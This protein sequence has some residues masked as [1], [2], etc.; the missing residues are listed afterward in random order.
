VNNGHI[1]SKNR[2]TLIDPRTGE[3]VKKSDT[4]WIPVPLVFALIRERGNVIDYEIPIT[5]DLNDPKFNFWDPIK[6]VLGNIFIKP[7]TVAYG[8]H[9][10]NVEN[11]LEK[12]INIK[13]PFHSYLITGETEKFVGK[14][15]KFLEENKDA[16]LEI[17]PN[18]HEEKEKEFI[19]I[20]EAKK[21]FFLHK[22]KKNRKN[23]KEE[24]SM[25]VEKMANKDP[26]FLAYL[27]KRISDPLLFTVQHKSLNVVGE[28][29]VVAKYE[30]L[31]TNRK[32][33]FLSCFPEE[34]R[35]RLDFHPSTAVV[36]FNGQSLYEIPL[37]FKQLS[38]PANGLELSLRRLLVK[39]G[40]S[41]GVLEPL[42]SSR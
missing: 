41:N 24:D 28:D 40:L 10:S 16:N 15:A 27:D 38:F 14:M 23:F 3:R 6:D 9:V 34:M 12:T 21:L 1:Q 20:Y 5:G 35:K 25:A 13:W 17:H 11:K 8:L 37:P 18:L 29:V 7:P 19:T 39:T 2:L 36:P 26:E 4:K 31:I 32:R 42:A 30:S 22:F 33:Q